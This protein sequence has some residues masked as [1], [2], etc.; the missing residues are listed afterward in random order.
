MFTPDVTSVAMPSNAPKLQPSA[1][2]SRPLSLR[3]RNKRD[4]QQRIRDAAVTLF[5][6]D[7]YSAVTTQQISETADVG[8][9]TLFR[10]FPTKADLLVAVMNHLLE[11]GVEQGLDAARAGAPVVDAILATV[12]PLVQAAITQPENTSIYQREALFG[13]DRP[14][15]SVSAHTAALRNAIEQILTMHVGP[16]RD[17]DIERVADAIFAT[18]YMELARG[19]TGHHDAASLPDRLGSTVTFLV[20]T[21]L[22]PVRD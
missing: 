20:E 18:M 3:E 16:R 14:R 1:A 19:T 10:Y 8:T 21:M 15:G 9:G 11:L 7:G 22:P 2:G 4:K 13:D 5:T 17:L 12:A 6:R